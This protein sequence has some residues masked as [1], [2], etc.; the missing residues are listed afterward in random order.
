MTRLASI[1]YL[2][3]LVADHSQ[4]PRI[5]RR[6]MTAV[7][8][9][10]QTHED[11]AALRPR[12]MRSVQYDVDASTLAESHE[13]DLVITTALT[14]GNACAPLWGRGWQLTGAASGST[15]TLA[16]GWPVPAAGDWLHIED[17]RG[18]LTAQVLSVAG[19]V[20]TLTSALSRAVTADAGVWPILFGRF[21]C[22][23]TKAQDGVMATATVRVAEPMG[24]GTRATQSCAT[25]TCPTAPTSVTMCEPPP[26]LAISPATA[27]GQFTLSWGSEPGATWKVWSAPTSTGTWTLVTTVT[28]TGYSADVP[29]RIGVYYSVT[30][31]R[32]DR[33][34]ERSNVVFATGVRLERLMRVL[35]ERRIAGGGTTVN[36]PDR[37]LP[38]AGDPGASPADGYFDADVA[39][40]GSGAKE[41]DLLQSIYDAFGASGGWVSKYLSAEIEGAT[42]VSTY[43]VGTGSFNVLPFTVTTGNR[44]TAMR[45][46]VTLLCLL[47]KCVR[48]GTVPVVAEDY[49]NWRLAES[50][51]SILNPTDAVADLRTNW[52]A[53]TWNHD[54]DG[55]VILMFGET[56]KLQS[57]PTPPDFGYLAKFWARRGKVTV[58]VT[59][60]SGS[61]E[62]Y[63]VTTP[64]SDEPGYAAYAP[65]EIDGAYHRWRTI[66]GG[67]TYLS[68]VLADIGGPVPGF[69]L[70]WVLDVTWRRG[71]IVA[72]RDEPD[73]PLDPIAAVKRSWTYLPTP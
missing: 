3:S 35:Q 15:I 11:R 19:Q 45:Q 39:A 5:E 2:G 30:V 43:D 31:I 67:S 72:A 23:G 62:L 34:S 7:A 63:L 56:S 49:A 33:E 41:R 10:V 17:G 64:F 6:W 37:V 26:T 48:F 57:P 9:G 1:V 27:C 60:L 61:V 71:W 22:E 13:L 14:E 55:G 58:D 54:I 12:A 47:N 66:T 73:Y 46:L 53:A 18:W 50:D 21:A 29:L 24:I 4:P 68:E 25:P 42:T 69:S 70:P 20:V 38:S 52:L 36:W 59:A 65:T 28:S 40:D 8:D 44:T 32:G 16:A 51:G